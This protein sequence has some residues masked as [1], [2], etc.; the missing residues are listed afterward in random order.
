MRKIFERIR[1]NFLRIIGIGMFFFGGKLLAVTSLIIV[2]IIHPEMEI[3]GEKLVLADP[4]PLTASSLFKL[5]ISFIGGGM[6][7][8]IGVLLMIGKFRNWSAPL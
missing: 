3:S 2:A 8:I 4:G 5:T 1:K 6:M 7:A